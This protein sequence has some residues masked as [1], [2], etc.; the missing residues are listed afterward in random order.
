[1]PT[2]IIDGHSYQSAQTIVK[3]YRARNAERADAGIDRLG[4]DG[5]DAPALETIGCH[6]C[7]A[8]VAIALLDVRSASMQRSMC[9]RKA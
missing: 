7:R 2:F 9:G 4:D 3:H 5:H 8:A 6:R 1:L